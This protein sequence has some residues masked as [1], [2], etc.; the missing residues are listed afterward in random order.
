MVMC[1]LPKYD[2]ISSD[3]YTSHRISNDEVAQICEGLKFD[4]N[5]TSQ[6]PRCFS[7]NHSIKYSHS[8]GI[9][10]KVWDV[11][12]STLNGWYGDMKIFRDLNAMERGNRIS[13]DVRSSLN[14]MMLILTWRTFNKFMQHLVHYQVDNSNCRWA[15]RRTLTIHT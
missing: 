4:D 8:I 15:K 5:I 11:T 7:I 1:R 9:I 13:F 2:F 6:T 14:F 10:R 12:T 3:S